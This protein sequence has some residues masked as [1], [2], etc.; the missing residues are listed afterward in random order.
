MY[1]AAGDINNKSEDR[2]RERARVSGV[3][4]LVSPEPPHPRAGTGR[5][6]SCPGIRFWFRTTGTEPGSYGL[7]QTAGGASGFQSKSRSTRCFSEKE[8]LF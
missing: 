3:F 1:R 2:A 5:P 6:R 7:D 4:M 8:T